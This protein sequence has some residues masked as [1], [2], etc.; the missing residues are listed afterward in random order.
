MPKRIQFY[1]AETKQPIPETIGQ[2]ARCCYDSLA[3]R[4]K[5]SFEQC[6]RLLRSNGNAKPETFNIIGGGSK[7][8]LLN[9][10]TADLVGVPVIAGPDEA[11][12]I[13][14]VL[15][16]AIA[17]GDIK[18]LEQGREVIRNSFDIS[19]FTPA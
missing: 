13:G 14:N 2:I 6:S 17:L 11:A 7:N 10:L 1:C 16:Q 15:A 19:F 5:K 12:V 18:D 4:Y 8:G 3:L 9:Q